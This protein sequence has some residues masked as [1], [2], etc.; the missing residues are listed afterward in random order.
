MAD[1]REAPREVLLY[2]IVHDFYKRGEVS[3]ECMDRVWKFM[4]AKPTAEP[5]TS[6]AA[7]P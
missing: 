3:E 6:K 1:L 4:D 2:D 7:R 5:D